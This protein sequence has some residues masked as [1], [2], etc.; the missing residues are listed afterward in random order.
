MASGCWINIAS[1]NGEIFSNTLVNDILF[2]GTTSNSILISPLTS[3]NIASLAINAQ[4]IDINKS[5]YIKGD[6]IPSENII[7]D[8]GSAE[9][10]F[11]DLYLS[12]NTIKLGDGTISYS[13]NIIS[14]ASGGEIVSPFIPDASVTTSKLNNVIGTGS[15]VLN[16]SPSLEGNISINGNIFGTCISSLLNDDKSNIIASSAAVKGVYE[17]ANAAV[18]KTGGIV[19]GNL[20]ID[21]STTFNSGILVNDS[22]PLMIVRGSNVVDNDLRILTHINE[23]DAYITCGRN[24]T[25]SNDNPIYPFYNE[26]LKPFNITANPLNLNN[27]IGSGDV[28]VGNNLKINKD[29]SIGNTSNYSFLTFLGPDQNSWRISYSGNS[30]DIESK[31]SGS[32]TKKLNIDKNGSTFATAFNVSS[33]DRVKTNQNIIK[34]ATD[35]INKLK[36][37]IYEKWN[38]IDFKNDSNAMCVRESGL[39][40]QQIFYDV[41][42]LRHVI[43]LPEGSDSN[44]LYSSYIDTNTQIDYDKLGWGSNL[45]SVNY[46]GLIPY[47]IKSLQEKDSEIQD[48]I[49]RMNIIESKL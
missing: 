48:L 22:Y 24:A 9:K 8:L 39:I 23:T 41:P 10:R 7:Y 49:K 14:F 12:G 1:S 45:A 17:L 30:F 13:N 47:L 42:E 43:C 15:I 25:L 35:T 19:T 34:N 36:A 18:P 46:T 32:Y 38:I 6:I 3:D 44:T 11:R 40:A 26:N 21:G 31:S 5:V 4:S 27:S 29:L 2:R 20:S 33:D 28:I 37:K 16:N